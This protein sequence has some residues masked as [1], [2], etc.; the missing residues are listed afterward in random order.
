MSKDN[1]TL[2]RAAIQLI[3]KTPEPVSIDFVATNLRINWGTARALL[4]ELVMNGQLG[5]IKTTK[6]WIF[7][8]PSEI[9]LPIQRPRIPSKGQDR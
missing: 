6:S 8:T 7:S 4:F 2:K 1:G 3:T 9:F 5:A